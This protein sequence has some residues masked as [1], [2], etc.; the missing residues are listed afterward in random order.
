[1]ILHLN[2]EEIRALRAGG[3]ALLEGAAESP[4]AVLAPAESLSVLEAFL[5]TLDGDLS[6]ST[7]D[8]V[9]RAERA[10]G[11]ILEHF[12]VEMESAVVATHAAD[13]QAVAAYFDWAHALTVSTRLGEMASEMEA[14]IEL[15]T[16]EEPNED[17]GR[18]FRFPD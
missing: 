2:F 9:R 13:E 14:V 12:F 16:G 15:V 7:L 17:A 10:V 3:R 18:T 1:V 8:E 11:A 5:P 4:S 6:L